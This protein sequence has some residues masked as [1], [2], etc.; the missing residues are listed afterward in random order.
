VSTPQ[1]RRQ[2]RV[3]ELCAA[4]IRALTGD[5]Q[6]HY[7]GRRLH[8][9]ATPFPAQAPHVRP[10]AE[11][12]FGSFRG[13][14][15]ALALRRLHSDPELHARLSPQ[16]DVAGLLFELLEQL[17]CE[18]LV[19]ARLAG[20]RPNLVHR[21]AT[22]SA[23]F[24]A[25][26]L[27]ETHTGLTLFTVAQVVR[28]R[29][30]GVPLDQAT[31]DHLEPARFSLAPVI[32][33][34]LREL[35]PSRTDQARYAVPARALAEAVA[36]LV[37]GGAEHDPGR[38]AQARTAFSLLLDNAEADDPAPLATS[39][40]SRVLAAASEGYRV[41]TRAYDR[42]RAIGAVVRPAALR[43]LRER[44]DLVVE[45]RGLNVPALA[46]HLRVLLH[47]PTVEGW[48]SAQEEGLVDGSRLAQLVTSPTERRLFRTERHEPRADCLVTFLID[49]SGS[50][51]RHKEDVATLV[52]VLTRALDLAGASS[53]AL[54]FTTGAWNGGRAMRDWR[55]AGRPAHPGRLNEVE[56]LVFKD[57]AA[58]WRRSRLGLGGLLRDDL[59]REGVDGEAVAWACSRMRGRDE[60]LRL[61]VVV[62]DGSPMDG[63]TNLANDEH[64]L[65]HHLREVVQREEADGSVRILG[66]GVGLDLT[67]FY[68]RSRVL[69]LDHGVDPRALREVL[70]LLARGV[71]R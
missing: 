16:G 29:L 67:P 24:L 58:G 26:G 25:S 59:Y 11:E 65:D 34:P 30:T 70:E 46:R 14:A 4:S 41:F 15:D 40:H 45:R 54:G 28:S 60:E 33:G 9:G 2:Q 52:D 63:A 38:A 7:R 18:S 56:H 37:E 71:R 61:L 19:P 6:L 12:D 51:R 69:D 1:V 3:D 5:P 23:G 49:C 17:R 44:L 66:L 47:R 55:R 21:Y 39:G 22:W 20:M 31:E 42:E 32:G 50:M 36:A 10:N 35:R 43:E 53:E 13:A 57:A 48:Q 62:S 68:S 27:T 64:Y 8:R